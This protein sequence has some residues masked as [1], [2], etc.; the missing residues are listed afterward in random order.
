M[1]W[2][3]GAKAY[4]AQAEWH[5][6]GILAPGTAA[7]LQAELDGHEVPAGSAAAISALLSPDGTGPATYR[8]S[9][10]RCPGRRRAA[11]SHVVLDVGAQGAPG[12]S[13]SCQAG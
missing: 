7:A 3:V 6:T 8:C 5:L 1:R 4:Q 11:L 13:R 2:S 9:D 10:D 12:G